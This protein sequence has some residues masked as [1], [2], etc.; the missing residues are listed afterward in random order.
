MLLAIYVIS[1]AIANHKFHILG[2]TGFCFYSFGYLRSGLWKNIDASVN[3][4]TLNIIFSHLARFAQLLN[5]T[6]IFMCIKYNDYTRSMHEPEKNQGQE[7]NTC[8]L[9]PMKIISFR[10]LLNLFYRIFQIFS[11]NSL[12]VNTCFLVF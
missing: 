10:F 3:A 2:S 6:R 1:P 8:D 4:Q 5:N 7:S 9:S 11:R 12:E